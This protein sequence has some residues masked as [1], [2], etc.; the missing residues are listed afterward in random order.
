MDICIKR[1]PVST[2]RAPVRRLTGASFLGGR[3]P[4]NKKLIW[5]L[6]TYLQSNGSKEEYQKKKKEKGKKKEGGPKGN[7][8]R[9]ISESQT[10]P[11]RALPHINVHTFMFLSK[12]GA[13]PFPYD[14]SAR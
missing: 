13:F 8:K 5:A 7:V 3:A 1:A 14:F 2:K 4:V 12:K 11:P 9:K 6:A 10:L